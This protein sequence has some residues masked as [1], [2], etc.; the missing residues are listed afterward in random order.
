[1][2][3]LTLEQAIL[4]K[5]RLL[6]P[7]KQQASLDFADFLATKRNCPEIADSPDCLL[8]A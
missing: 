3:N 2:N 4:E 8:I 5:V 6:P 1:M 7:E